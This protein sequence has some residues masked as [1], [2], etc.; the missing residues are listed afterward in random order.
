MNNYIV[1]TQ[2]KDNDF[3]FTPL[4]KGD[5]EN[6]EFINCTFNELSLAS[7]SF[8]E[9]RFIRCH[10]NACPINKTSWREV[11]FAESKI[12]GLHFEES[13][14]PMVDITIT[15]STLELCSFNDMKLLRLI[16][17]DSKLLECDF[18]NTH[19]ESAQLLMCNFDKSIFENTHLVK[20]NLKGSYNF[21]IDPDRNMVKQAVF[22][23][24]AIQGLLYKYQ[25][26]LES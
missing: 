26:I 15:D 21:Y 18:S 2:F 8:C 19:M 7:F 20:A 22:S 23:L 24:Q 25:I 13:N 5:Y 16:I 9:C 11:T 12:T 10:F 3:S 17:K 1:D 6:C 14:N 4:A